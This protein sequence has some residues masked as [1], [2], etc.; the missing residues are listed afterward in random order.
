LC[1]LK[2]NGKTFTGLLDSGADISIISSDQ[3]PHTWPNKDVDSSI[4]GVGTMTASQLQQSAQKLKCEGPEDLQAILQP[5]ITQ[6]PMN[7]WS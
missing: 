7:L 3:W 4:Q 5:Y 1:T 2:I 6:I